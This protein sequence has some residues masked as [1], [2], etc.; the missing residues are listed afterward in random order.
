MEDAR[1]GAGEEQVRPVA[2]AE[3]RA[4]EQQLRERP[5][6]E[7]DADLVGDGLGAGVRS[8]AAAGGRAR[9]PTGGRAAR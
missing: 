9:R 8:V 7:R 5:R 2:E 4:H 6:V 3:V 1:E